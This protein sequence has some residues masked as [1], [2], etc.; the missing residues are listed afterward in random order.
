MAYLDNSTITV[1]AILTNKGRQILAQNGTLNITSFALA[2]DEINYNLYQPNHPLG[3]AY[4]DLAVRN[5]PVLEPFSDET[6]ALKHKLVTLP[7]GV[8]SI[9]VVSAAQTNIVT[10]KNY[11]AQIVI[12]PST[13]PTY[14]TTLGYTA[15]LINKNVGSL[16]VTQTNSLNSTSATIPSFYGSAISETSQVVVGTQFQFVPN[17]TLVSTT[18]T[19]IIIIGNESGGSVTIPVTVTV[20]TTTTS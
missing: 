19:Q 10:D 9:P 4:Y 3:S 15:I 18:S 2:D 5:T 7:A 16:T 20:A 17:S 12:A 13:N 1:Q 11:S 6:Q 14:D 8:T